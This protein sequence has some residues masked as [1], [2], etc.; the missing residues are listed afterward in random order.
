MTTTNYTTMSEYIKGFDAGYD[1]VLNEVEKFK[2]EH[3]GE[4]NVLLC[5]LLA[6]LHMEHMKATEGDS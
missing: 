1:Y 4:D 6:R 5:Q 2:N 3:D